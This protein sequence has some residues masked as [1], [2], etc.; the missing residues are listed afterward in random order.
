MNPV[1]KKPALLLACLLLAG[2]S[3]YDVEQVAFSGHPIGAMTYIAEARTESLVLHPWRLVH[4][5]SSLAHHLAYIARLLRGHVSGTWGRR[6]TV[7]PSPH[8]YVKYTQNYKSRAIVNFD[9][10]AIVV[11]TLD[12][13]HPERSLHNAIV[14][15]LLTPA[16]PRAVDLYNASTVKLS[17]TPYLYGLVLDE[18][19]HAIDSPGRAARFAGY[20]ERAA[21]HTR[22]VDTP[23]GRKR[24]LYVRF[25]MV[26]DHLRLAARRYAPLAAR[27]ASRY[28]VSR[29][30][31]MAIIK[32]ESDFNP[33]AVSPAPA[34]GLMQLVPQ[35]GGADAYRAVTGHQ[36]IPSP[37]SLLD[38]P[39]NIELGSAYLGLLEHD[40]LAG[41]RN[42]VSREY[43]AI[44]AYNAGSGAVLRSF[45][46]SP[47]AAVERINAMGP[48]AV[49]RHLRRTMN[50]E[51]SR[52]LWKVV[53]ARKA[54]VSV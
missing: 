33:F 48:A 9:S 50:T 4:D 25:T 43:C 6:D 35:T 54:F 7:L 21:Q 5:A 45:S 37:H 11:E 17:G 1:H 38:G 41:I 24:A 22:L 3:M 52:Y 13:Q 8:R 53:R 42:P 28:H 30:L 12:Q 29:S 32:T 27:Y 23:A 19:G 18:Q 44:A 15:T 51:A 31:V 16:D 36:G 46:A 34:Y 49:Y 2:C 39:R 40:Y 14:T 47:D 26:P 10:G 20:L